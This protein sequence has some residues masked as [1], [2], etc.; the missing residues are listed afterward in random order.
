MKNTKPRIWLLGSEFGVEKEILKIAAI[1]G[2]GYEPYDA[3]S[4]S[5]MTEYQGVVWKTPSPVRPNL[6]RHEQ[7]NTFLA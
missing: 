6:E 3:G 4:A 5:L 7:L 2:G 1:D